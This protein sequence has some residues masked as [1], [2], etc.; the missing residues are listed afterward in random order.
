V[1]ARLEAEANFAGGQLLFL[2][3]KFAEDGNDCTPSIET[4]KGLA[5]RFGNTITSTLWRF[6]EEAHADKLLCGCRK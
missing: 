6:V 5:G 3:Q 1:H 2:Q 4:V